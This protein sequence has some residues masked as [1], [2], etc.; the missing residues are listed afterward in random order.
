MANPVGVLFH[1]STPPADLVR[2]CQ[3][4]EDVGFSE[5]WLSED[6]FLMGAFSSAAMALQGTASIP[7]GIGIV[8]SIARHPAVAAMEISTLASAYPGRL[9]VGIGHGVP[10]WTKQMGLYPKSQIRALREAVT[11]IR[12]LLA[13]ETVN[14]SGHFQFEAIQLQ[15]PA[16]GVPIYTGVVGPK[17]LALSGEVADGTVISA[18]AGPKYVEYAR[19]LIADAS[20]TRVGEHTLPVY[21]LYCVDEDRGKAR[22]VA[23]SVAAFY[24]SAMGPT[25]LTEVYGINDVLKDLIAQGG[26]ESVAA[27]MPDEWLDW[28]TIAGEPEE[29]AERIKL[30]HAAGASSVVLAP[31]PAETTETQIQLTA[32]RVLPKL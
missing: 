20:A 26:P 30:R 17:S 16:D 14:E 31:V 6:Y 10:A 25:A 32:A 2:L 3:I 7:V 12:R 28:L 23:R 18:L 8:S 19:K 13:G 29:C 21:A 9:R 15:H 24:L 1:G 4:A 27:E 22:S 5:L 11:S